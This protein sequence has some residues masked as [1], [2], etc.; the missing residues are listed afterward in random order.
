MVSSFLGVPSRSG[1]YFAR[2]YETGV[3]P[4]D[5]NLLHDDQISTPLL[6]LGIFLCTQKLPIQCWLLSWHHLSENML[7]VIEI[8]M[9]KL[10]SVHNS[11][12]VRTVWTA[13]TKLAWVQGVKWDHTK[14]H[15]SFRDVKTAHIHLRTDILLV[16]IFNS[17]FFFSRYLYTYQLTCLI[18]TRKNVV[19]EVVKQLLLFTL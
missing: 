6:C 13:R 10:G 1:C 9:W 3:V 12:E 7:M 15:L 8:N 16:K 18:Q 14:M 17:I 11:V 2:K 19:E 4:S 5:K